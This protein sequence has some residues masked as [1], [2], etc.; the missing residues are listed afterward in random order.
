M[1]VGLV[2]VSPHASE[3]LV[4]SL[5]YRSER[6]VSANARFDIDHYEHGILLIDAATHDE[7]SITG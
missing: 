4:A 2:K 5:L 3:Y 6:M 1:T 7:S